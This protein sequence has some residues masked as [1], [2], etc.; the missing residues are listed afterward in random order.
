MNDRATTVVKIDGHDTRFILDTGA[1]FSHMSLANADALGLKREP[2]PMGFYESG[3][4]GSYRPEVTT[5]RD[6]GILGVT[7]HNIDFTVGG[8]D[9][10]MG[11]IG[12]N[13]LDALDLDIDLAQGKLHLMKPGGDC[14]KTS[15]GW[16]AKDGVYQTA[17]LDPSSR[18]NDRRSFV[19]VT[20][21]GKPFRAALDT[22]A[23]ATVLSRHAAE[24]AGIDLDAPSVKASYATS[25]LGAKSYKTWIAPIDIFTVGTETIQHSRMQVMDGN[26]GEGAEAPDMLLGVDFFLAHHMFIANSQHRIYFTYNGGRVFS[27]AQAPKGSDVQDVAAAGALDTPVTAADYALRG[28]SHLS[29]GEPNAAL[30][31]LDKAIGMAA[32]GTG[33]PRPDWYAARA[34]THLALKQS[35][36]A[37]ADLDKAIALDP[38]NVGNLLLRA[39]LKLLAKDKAGAET[40]IAAARQAAPAG[41]QQSRAVAQFYMAADRPAE[42]LP[43]L[44]AWIRLHDDDSGLG[45]VL[46]SRCWARGLANVMLDK[47]LPDCRKA[48][49]RDGANPA[50]LDSLALIQ[51]RQKDYAGAIANYRQA[52]AGNPRSAWSRYGLGLAELRGGQADAGNADLAAAKLLNSDIAARFA[53]FGI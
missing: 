34:H 8:S 1:W 3:I 19:T 35:D 5:V 47:A 11:L 10:G 21:N 25:G 18:S 37:R 16:W 15:L 14:H 49:R 39:H 40:D 28:Q 50:Y 26:I 42:A 20:I 2:L 36:A 32:V 24:R 29:R 43:L 13:F 45:E 33:A 51:L 23:T 44:D 4:G 6:F 48:I 46:N 12:A 9:P 38:G 27:L 53:Q 31:D 52:V 30:A 17:D 7:L 41:S 22:G